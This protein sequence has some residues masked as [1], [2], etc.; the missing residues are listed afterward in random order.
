[1]QA[2]VAR[3]L[4]LG[5][6][7]LHILRHAHAEPVYGAWLLRELLSHG[8]EL[9]PGTLYPILHGMEKDGLLEMKSRAVDGKLRKYYRCTEQGEAML[10]LGKRKAEALLAELRD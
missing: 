7:Q 2:K 3:K 1:M 9:S 5:F 10:G 8:Y 4:F 6:I